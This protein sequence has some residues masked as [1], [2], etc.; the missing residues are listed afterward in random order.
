MCLLVRVVTGERCLE[1][2]HTKKWSYGSIHSDV[3]WTDVF[4]LFF[5]CGYYF[6]KPKNLIYLSFPFDCVNRSKVKFKVYFYSMCVEFSS[7]PVLALLVGLTDRW[8]TCALHRGGAGGTLGN[9]HRIKSVRDT[10][11]REN[12]RGTPP[13]KP[14]AVRT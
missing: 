14:P 7:V 4:L 10:S 8:T 9:R 3:Q 6:Q 12:C 2:L 11:R 5:L 13:T 1:R